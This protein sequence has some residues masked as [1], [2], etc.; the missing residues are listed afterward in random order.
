MKELGLVVTDI[1]RQAFV[2]KVFCGDDVH[3]ACS[4]PVKS[5]IHYIM[6]RR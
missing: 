5:V 6:L 2:A 3:M 4:V 1:K